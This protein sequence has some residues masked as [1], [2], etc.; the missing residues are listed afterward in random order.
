MKSEADIIIPDLLKE[1]VDEKLTEEWGL[2]TDSL[3][4]VQDFEDY[5][6]TIKEVLKE[7]LRGVLELRD[8]AAIQHTRQHEFLHAFDYLN[9][10]SESEDKIS[11]TSELLHKSKSECLTYKIKLTTS[12]DE[13]EA[14]RSC[15]MDFCEMQKSYSTYP[16]ESFMSEVMTHLHDRFLKGK[17]DGINQEV[18]HEDQQSRSKALIIIQ[19]SIGHFSKRTKELGLE[20][21]NLNSNHELIER[22]I[23]SYIKSK[24]LGVVVE[25][26]KEQSSSVG[27][28]SVKGLSRPSGAAS[29]LHQDQLLQKI[30][31]GN[32]TLEQKLLPS[33]GVKSM[34]V[35]S[36]SNIKGIVNEGRGG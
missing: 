12:E 16:D 29:K 28:A 5:K 27:A 24:G 15:I 1:K 11:I 20:S 9:S 6:D 33:S 17:T 31:R 34:S 2:V 23:L 30:L 14:I 13:W 21:T 22:G 35:S 8:E 26:A 36:L 7:R 4:S 10:R 18:E 25:S 19:E 3:T 32:D